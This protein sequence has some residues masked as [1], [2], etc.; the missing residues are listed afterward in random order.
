MADVSQEEFDARVEAELALAYA[1]A[2]YVTERGD[3]DE[4]AI[5]DRVLAKVL[6]ARVNALRER[7][8]TA[9]TRSA[10][11][12]ALFPDLPGSGQFDDQPDPAV[13]AK[14]WDKINTHL[15][16]LQG[17]G[18]G[19][20][21]QRRLNGEHAVVLC[22]TG[23]TAERGVQGTYVTRDRECLMIDMQHAHNAEIAKAIRKAGRDVEMV[24]QRI[25][26]LGTVFRND[27][28]KQTRNVLGAAVESVNAQLAM[29]VDDTDD[30][31]GDDE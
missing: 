18:A 6:G 16:A 5:E 8:H 29:V 11:V 24:V 12:R 15:W 7:E 1:Q 23:A 26:E 4:G 25:P 3:V 9:I 31:D 13:A 10:M 2:G 17:A 27:F 30:G 28:R 14:V 19:G 20:R 21:I 22:R